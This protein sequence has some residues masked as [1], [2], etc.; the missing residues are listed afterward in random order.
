MVARVAFAFLVG[1]DKL[2]FVALFPGRSN[3]NADTALEYLVRK[4]LP[5]IVLERRIILKFLR[6]LFTRPCRPRGL[7][8]T[9]ASRRNRLGKR[10]KASTEWSVAKHQRDLAD[11][12]NEILVYF[13]FGTQGNTA[14]QI[15]SM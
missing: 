8:V 7:S 12:L 3:D 15:M 11:L 9:L 6:P 2:L 10:P 4:M 14:A 5:R 1:H 13:D